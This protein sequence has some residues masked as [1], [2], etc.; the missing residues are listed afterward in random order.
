[1]SQGIHQKDNYNFHYEKGI[2][3][4]ISSAFSHPMVGAYH[5]E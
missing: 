2:E 1:V 5:H 4:L 3:K